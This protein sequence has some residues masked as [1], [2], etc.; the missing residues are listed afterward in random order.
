LTVYIVHLP[1]SEVWRLSMF[2]GVALQSQE[3]PCV[4]SLLRNHA[5]RLVMASVALVYKLRRMFPAWRIERLAVRKVRPPL[6][7]PLQV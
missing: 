7:R 6:G 4:V 1:K 5:V 3:L 2:S